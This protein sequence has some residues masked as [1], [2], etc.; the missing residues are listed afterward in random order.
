M[1][2]KDIESLSKKT[3]ADGTRLF[4]VCETIYEIAMV[5]IGIVAIIGSIASVVAGNIVFFWGC[6]IAVCTVGFCFMSYMLAVI[7]THV[8]KVMVHTSFSS[9][10]IL[11]HLVSESRNALNASEAG[12]KA[13]NESKNRVKATVAGLESASISKTSYSEKGEQIIQKIK[14]NETLDLSEINAIYKEVYGVEVVIKNGLFSSN[15]YQFVLNGEV[16]N[17]NDYASLINFLMPLIDP[18]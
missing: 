1:N 12:L 15:T 5:G 10:A 17:F 9:I 8:S 16:C 11:E 6:I 18:K 2:F 4:G 3:R 13:Q 7:A 14:L